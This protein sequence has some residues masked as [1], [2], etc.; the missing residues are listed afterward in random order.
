MTSNASVPQSPPPYAPP[1]FTPRRGSRFQRKQKIM[2]G[3][4]G[5]IVLMMVVGVVIALSSSPTS[6]QTSTATATPTVTLTTVAP[7]STVAPLPTVTSLRPTVTP[8]RP[9]HPP[10]QR[11]VIVQ[12]GNTLFQI[13]SENCEGIQ[14]AQIEDYVHQIARL[15]RLPNVD[16]VLEGQ[17]LDLLDCP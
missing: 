5:A 8:M 15:N 10:R 1:V 13:A 9:A 11:Q 3:V 16:S 17:T 4:T 2:L 6:S 7:T 14:P 12:P